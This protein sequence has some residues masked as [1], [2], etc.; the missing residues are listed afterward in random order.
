MNSRSSKTAS[1]WKRTSSRGDIR[2]KMPYPFDCKFTEWLLH[3]HIHVLRLAHVSLSATLRRIL[4]CATSCSVLLCSCLNVGT[5]RFV[6]STHF[7]PPSQIIHHFIVT[8]PFLSLANVFPHLDRP[9]LSPQLHPWRRLSFQTIP[10]LI[11][12]S[13]L[14]APP[15]RNLTSATQQPKPQF[16]QEWTRQC[17]G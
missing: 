11:I 9:R 8:V 16:R 17:E 14:L 10:E 13:P 12:T 3:L 15:T 2:C 1:T 5:L 4:S 7:L 6:F